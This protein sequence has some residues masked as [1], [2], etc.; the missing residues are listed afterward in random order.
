[1]GVFG[2]AIFERKATRWPLVLLAST[3]GKFHVFLYHFEG[4]WPMM[5]LVPASR[6][7]L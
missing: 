4:R 1:M 3:N 7:V 2:A 6:H 5:I